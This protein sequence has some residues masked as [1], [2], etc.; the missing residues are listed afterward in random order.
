[1]TKEEIKARKKEEVDIV[2]GVIYPKIPKEY[3]EVETEIRFLYKRFRPIMSL[4]EVKKLIDR[5]MFCK[6]RDTEKT[7][8][9]YN[10]PVETWATSEE[11]DLWS[12]HRRCT[13]PK[14]GWECPSVEACTGLYH[15]CIKCG[16][17]LPYREKVQILN[18]SEYEALKENAEKSGL[19]KLKETIFW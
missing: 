2:K 18:S 17:L 9:C 6:Y 8:T 13:N 19:R 16:Q 15:Y 4:G 3:P 14:C 1:M 11:I 12:K 10:I 5:F 7:S